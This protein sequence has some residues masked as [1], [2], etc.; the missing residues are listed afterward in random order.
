MCSDQNISLIDYNEII[1][2]DIHLN[3]G[4]LHLSNYENL[5]FT[6]FLLQID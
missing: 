6:D 4:K 1:L 3:K 2:P 5:T